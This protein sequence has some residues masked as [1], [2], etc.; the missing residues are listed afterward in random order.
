MIIE[1]LDSDSGHG[2]GRGRW[3]PPSFSPLLKKSCTLVCQ[4]L[5]CIEQTS[6]GACL[7]INLVGYY[8]NSVQEP[9]PPGNILIKYGHVH[10]PTVY[11]WVFAAVKAVHLEVGH[12]LIS[13][14]KLLLLA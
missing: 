11:I 1:K 9:P 3:R 10:K 5:A 14:Q 12:M 2:R 4:E 7:Q 6:G 8:A 13:L